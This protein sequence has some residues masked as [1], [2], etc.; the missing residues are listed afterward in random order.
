MLNQKQTYKSDH[1]ELLT[2]PL[3]SNVS[4]NGNTSTSSLTCDSSSLAS[5]NSCNFYVSD[6][7][8]C[9]IIKTTTSKSI[10]TQLDDLLDEAL[11]WI[12]CKQTEINSIQF[13]PDI[14]L[15]ELELARL[16]SLTLDINKFH[17][18]L[19]QIELLKMDHLE[20]EDLNSKSDETFTSFNYL[21]KSLKLTQQDLESLIEFNKLIQDELRYINEM[22]DIE[23]NRDWSQPTKLNSSDLIQHKLNVELTLNH[24]KSKI[25]YIQNFAKRLIESKHPA[26][27][28]IS[29]YITTLASETQWLAQLMQILGVHVTHLQLFESLE[30]EYNCLNKYLEESE[31]KFK[32]FSNS[33]DQFNIFKHN[34][35]MVSQVKQQIDELYSIVNKLPAF[36]MRKMNLS[37]NYNTAEILIEY[38]V[39][40][41]KFKKGEL[42][43][44]EDNSNF[45][46][47]KVISKESN[48]DAYVP[49]V[50]FVLNGPDLDLVELVDKIRFKFENLNSHINRFD[51][52]LKKESIERMMRLHISQE[53]QQSLSINIIEEKQMFTKSGKF[54]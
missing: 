33:P 42:C 43:K 34:F 54:V 51:A 5:T 21:C 37:E 31:Q 48:R 30:K 9:C 38:N 4:F 44:I 6:H 47:W 26:S 53:E 15:N 23:L 49:S 25:S 36:K 39:V 35:Q 7:H 32:S 14:A 52:Y 27:E 41:Y 2:S 18:N 1:F 8:R 17:T 19:D 12:K 16:R 29:N 45:V 50:C 46:K 13:K 28:E 3:S 10:N 11:K 40:G 20:T 22:E 24:K